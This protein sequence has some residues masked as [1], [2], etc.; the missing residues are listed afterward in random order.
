[1]KRPTVTENTVMAV[2]HKEKYW[3]QSATNQVAK[4]QD[5]TTMAR[6]EIEIFKSTC[7]AWSE[8]MDVKF[9]LQGMAAAE[10]TVVIKKSCLL[11]L[12]SGALLSK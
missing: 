1:M 12:R 10:L 5:Y 6:K 7:L 11:C 8:W 2:D 3:L 4:Q 9:T